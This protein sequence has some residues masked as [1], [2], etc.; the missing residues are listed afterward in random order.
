M[1]NIEITL[2]NKRE[3][4]LKVLERFLE[5]YVENDMVDFLEEELVYVMVRWL[6]KE[7]HLDKKVRGLFEARV[8][9]DN[10]QGGM[11]NDN[12]KE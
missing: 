5:V 12:S 9:F 2:E 7:V 4:I 1:D 6:E 11:G 8:N 3:R 10:T